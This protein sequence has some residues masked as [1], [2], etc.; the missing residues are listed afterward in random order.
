MVRNHNLAQRILDASWGKFIQL[1][2]YKAERAAK[3]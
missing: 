3:K 2:L 1:L